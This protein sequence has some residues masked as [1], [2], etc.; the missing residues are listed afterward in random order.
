MRVTAPG[1]QIAGSTAAT[2]AAR[3]WQAVRDDGAIQ[4][5]PVPHEKPP[6]YPDWLKTMLKHLSEALQSVLEWIGRGL[7]AVGEALGLSWPVFEKILIAL[8]ALGV[9]F[10]LWKLVIQPLLNARPR[11]EAEPEW[12]PDRAA[13]IALLEDADR[14]AAEGRFGEATHLLLQR[15]V[16]HIATARPDWLDPAS[17]AREI[18]ILPSLPQRARD[19]FAQIAV[20][21]ERS[22]FALR[23]LDVADWQAARAAYADF[24]LQ[25][26][27]APA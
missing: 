9:L 19:A 18:A 1:G 24:A 8:A 3:D 7:K 25:S 20:R 4:F 12:T 10:L 15:S 6:E 23:D 21:V 27:E 22:L 2:D 5:A 16:H 26:L 17:T 14:L 13:A 11:A